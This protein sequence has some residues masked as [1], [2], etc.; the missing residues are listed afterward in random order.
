MSH[1]RL[2][3]LVAFSCNPRLLCL[4]DHHPNRM[5]AAS[6]TALGASSPKSLRKKASTF[7]ADS[8]GDIY[9]TPSQGMCM[10]FL[11]GWGHWMPNGRLGSHSQLPVIKQPLG[12]ERSPDHLW[13]LAQQRLS[14]PSCLLGRPI[15]WWSKNLITRQREGPSKETVIWPGTAINSQ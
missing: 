8:C 3:H 2:V 9:S 15:K 6:T 11:G 12:R 4:P 5:D 14:S 10:S 1:S 7:L 13:A